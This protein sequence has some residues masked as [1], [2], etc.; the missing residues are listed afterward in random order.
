MKLEFLMAIGR[1]SLSWPEGKASQSHPQKKGK[2]ITNLSV[3]DTSK[4]GI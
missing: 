1:K 4:E 2:S 3:V